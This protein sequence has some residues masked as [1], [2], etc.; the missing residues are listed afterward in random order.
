MKKLITLFAVLGLVLALAPAAQAELVIVVDENIDGN[1]YFSWNGTIGA[2]G[3]GTASALNPSA[4][5]IVPN[6]GNVQAGDRTTNDQG[7]KWKA[8]EYYAGTVSLYGSGAAFSDFLTTQNIPFFAKGSDG[9]LHVGYT[10]QA[11]TTGIPDLSSQ[12]FTGSFSLP[13]DFST[14]GLFTAGYELPTPLWTAASGTGS[15]V[16]KAL[17]PEIDIIGN[18]NSITNGDITPILGDH[19]DFGSAVVGDPTIVRTYTVTN[20]GTTDLTLSNLAVTASQFSVGTLASPVSAGGATTFTVTYTS[21]V[22]AVH[23]ATVSLVN[24][25]S[26]ENPYTFAITAETTAAPEPEI[27]VTG[28]G[29]SIPDGATP[30]IL[31]NH[32]DFGSTTL[33]GSTIVRTYTVE[34]TGTALLTLT[35]PATVSGAGAGQFTVGTLTDTTLNNGET[36]TFTVTYTPSA[37]A[38]VHNATVSLVNDD[39]DEN[40]YNFDIKAET[41]PALVIY[42]NEDIANDKIDFAWNGIIGASGTA[43]ASAL[44][45]SADQI[46]PNTGNVQAGDRTTND[47]TTK[48]KAS[49]YYAGTVSQYGSGGS[50][51]DFLTTQNIPFFVKGSD[52]TLHVGYTDQAT[53][54]GIPDLSSQT[55][56]GSFSLTNNLAHYGLFT[57]GYELPLTLWTAGS[58]DG[59]VVFAAGTPPGSAPGPNG[60]LFIFK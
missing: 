30:P 34:N 6:T 19:T 13:G 58:G 59:A 49:E 50:F 53:T 43:T 22:A 37:A 21:A 47:Q 57:T 2:S 52:G 4:D 56:T 38:A 46:V 25:D 54:T 24:D 40:P 14:Y 11:T 16:F 35:D 17:G 7:S 42:V 45:P 32:T 20:S 3:T 31:G 27:D 23:N 9:T 5:Q 29:V 10:N 39:S 15:I 33:A 18:G 28:S 51:S 55:F 26:D 48:W 60:T 41:T 36:A 8:S 12:T 44:N 1:I